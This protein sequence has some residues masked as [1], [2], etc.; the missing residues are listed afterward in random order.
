MDKIKASLISTNAAIMPH[1]T[2]YAYVNGEIRT[3]VMT[4]LTTKYAKVG[5][6]IIVLNAC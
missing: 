3:F 2:V 6:D 5:V 4:A 1:S